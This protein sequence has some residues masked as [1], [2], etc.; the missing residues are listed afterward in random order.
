MGFLKGTRIAVSVVIM[1]CEIKFDHFFKEF[2]RENNCAESEDLGDDLVAEA[3]IP[4]PLAV[5]VAQVKYKLNILI[6]KL[7]K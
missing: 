2:L 7:G 6:K 3:G 4:G 5:T 1:T